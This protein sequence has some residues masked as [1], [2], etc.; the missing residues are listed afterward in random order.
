MHLKL[1]HVPASWPC[2]PPLLGS[3][4]FITPKKESDFD[5]AL[6]KKFHLSNANFTTLFVFIQ[7]FRDI[8]FWKFSAFISLV[9]WCGTFY[10][11]PC[12]TKKKVMP[13]SR[14]TSLLCRPSVEFLYGFLDMLHIRFIHPMYPF[15]LTKYSCSR[16]LSWLDLST[17]ST[18]NSSSLWTKSNG[19][20]E[21][22]Y[23][24]GL[25]ALWAT[26]LKKETWNVAWIPRF[27][28]SSNL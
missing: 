21:L 14:S 10:M 3:R 15:H 6:C 5:L 18:S 11:T 2:L 26:I 13:S 17:A 20:L 19:G 23:W 27:F 22:C 1:V 28:G 7:Y 9:T 16:P 8:I 4:F 25:E 12:P 24:L